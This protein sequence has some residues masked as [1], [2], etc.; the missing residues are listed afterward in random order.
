MA[1]RAIQHAQVVT[2]KCS[3]LNSA[4]VSISSLSRPRSL[5]SETCNRQQLTTIV[6]PQLRPASLFL[7][8]ALRS[9]DGHVLLDDCEEGETHDVHTASKGL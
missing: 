9:A 8:G 7:T 4:S 1:T 3:K 5:C 6:Q 2:T